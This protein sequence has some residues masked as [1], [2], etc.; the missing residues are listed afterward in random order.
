MHPNHPMSATA[1]ATCGPLTVVSLA[2]LVLPYL[3][4]LVQ[5][6]SVWRAGGPRSQLFNAL[7]Y[8]S[9]LPAL[10]LTAIEHEYHVNK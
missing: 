3:L 2:A 5:C 6:L 7:K 4:R 9:S 8:A 10:I 1:A